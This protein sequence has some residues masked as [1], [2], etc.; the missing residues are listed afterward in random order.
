[1]K[2]LNFSL[3]LLIVI[4][5]SIR[6]NIDLLDL[7]VYVNEWTKLKKLEYG[8][9]SLTNQIAMRIR[10]IARRAWMKSRSFCF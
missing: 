1:M 5:I 10:S 4:F 9:S 7:F 8:C 2:P 6:C 3:S